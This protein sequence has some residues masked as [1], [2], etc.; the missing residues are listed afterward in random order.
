MRKLWILAAAILVFSSLSL[1]LP[2][3]LAELHNYVYTSVVPIVTSALAFAVYLHSDGELRRAAFA[4]S[5]FSFLSWLAEV[6]WNCYELLG[7][8]PFPSIADVFYLLSYVPVIYI[9]AKAFRECLRF[10]SARALAASAVSVALAAILFAPSV[11]V[12]MGMSAVKAALSLAYIVLDVA[13]VAMAI[14]VVMTAKDVTYAGIALACIFGFAGDVLFNYYEAAGIYYTGSLPDVFFNLSYAILLIVTCA[15]YTK[16]VRILSFDEVLRER[17]LYAILNRVLRH[18]VLNDLTA[19]IAYLDVLEERCG[20]EVRKVVD[21][22]E[23]AV[24]QINMVR[25]VEREGLELKAVN[26]REVVEDIAKNYPGLIV[27]VDSE[28]V[29][30]D[31]LLYSVVRNLIEN[32]FKYGKPPVRVYTRVEG[33]WL[34]LIVEDAGEGVPEEERDKVFELGYGRGSGIGLYLVKVAVERYGGEVRCE[35]S[36]FVVRLRRVRNSGSS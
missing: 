33:D 6:T 19:A 22:L 35:G 9:M 15:I 4:I 27:E 31:E 10:A 26:V 18:D 24:D 32:A 7:Y 12:A 23:R 25:A 16:D 30:A 8:T 34:D 2:E 1:F 5:A 3:R 28:E 29:I 17:E 11:R 14:P 13:V 36:R 20:K 21:I